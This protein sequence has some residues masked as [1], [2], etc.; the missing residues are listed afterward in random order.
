[1]TSGIQESSP[2]PPPAEAA[3]SRKG[4]FQRIIGVLFSPGETF[5]DIAAKPDFLAPIIVILIVSIASSIVIAP[6]VDFESA[7]REQM[8][9]S[10]K[11]SPADVD[12]AVRFASAFAKAMLY[13][14][15]VINFIFFGVI[16]GVLL[17]A[18]RLFG[19][20]GGFK[21]ALSATLYAW[22]P[23]IIA[24][25]IGMIILLARGSVSADQLANL[26]MSNLGFM[27]DQKENMVAFALL[28]SIDVFVIWTL[29]LLII[30]FSHLSKMSTGKS[31]AIVLSLWAVILVFKVGFAAMGAARMKS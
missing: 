14:A 21:Q 8:E 17:L 27:V 11:M 20:E 13:A 3:S 7:I 15:P 31:A 25:L 18:F 26:V 2:T 5:R 28:S 30:G 19:G 10:G 1:M 6:R 29:A 16:A 22:M 12:R 23:M 9:E 4:G 24:G